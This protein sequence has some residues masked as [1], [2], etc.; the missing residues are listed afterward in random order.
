MS[1]L[2][3]RSPFWFINQ[4]PKAPESDLIF[5]GLVPD[6]RFNGRIAGRKRQYSILQSVLNKRSHFGSDDHAEKETTREND[7]YRDN[8]GKILLRIRSGHDQIGYGL[9]DVSNP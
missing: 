4:P 2:K 5:Q 8:I 7:H 1:L 9:N 6:D 3:K